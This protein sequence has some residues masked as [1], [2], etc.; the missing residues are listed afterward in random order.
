[1]WRAWSACSFAGHERSSR[2][3]R[4]GRAGGRTQRRRRLS[5]LALRRRRG[6]A[7]GGRAALPAGAG[8]RRFG[9]RRPGPG[10]AGC[11][12]RLR[13]RPALVLGAQV[14]GRRALRAAVR[15]LWLRPRSAWFDD[16]ER[17]P[18][19]RDGRW[20]RRHGGRRA[21]ARVRARLQQ[22]PHRALQPGRGVPG[23]MGNAGRGSRATELRDQRRDRAERRVPLRR[24]SDQPP[25]PA[26]PPRPRRMARQLA[27]ARLRLVR[28]RRGPVQ[29]R[30]GRRRRSGAQPRRVRR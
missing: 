13:R 1:M 6:R 12:V 2:C 30:A 29:L 21:R 17:E 10:R 7:P 26:L 3:C 19:H 15:R 9:R 5:R 25:R 18:D 16:G 22:R 20:R 8:V 4:P 11:A 27:A 23:S 14:H 28:D 24:R